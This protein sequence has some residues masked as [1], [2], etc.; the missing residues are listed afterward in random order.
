MT[1]VLMIPTLVKAGASHPW[2][3]WGGPKIRL[4]MINHWYK[5]PL[6]HIE[7]FQNST[8]GYS[9]IYTVSSEYLSGFSYKPSTKELRSQ[10]NDIHST[11]SE[12]GA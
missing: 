1:D 2:D 9:M 11:F 5:F 6:E 3:R 8:S 4:F 7:K 12:L 10:V